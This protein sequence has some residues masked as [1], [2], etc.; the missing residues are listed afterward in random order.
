MARNTLLPGNGNFLRS[1]LSRSIHNVLNRKQD[2]LLGI[3][4]GALL[5]GTAPVLAQ[6][7]SSQELE[8][9]VV[10]GLRG[11]LQASME[12]KRDAIGVVDAINAEDIGKFPGFESQRIPATHHRHLDQPARWRRRTGHGARIRRRIQHGHAERPHDAG[13]GCLSR[14]QRWATSRAFNFANLASESGERGR[15]LQDQQGRHRHRRHRRDGEH[16]D[17]AAARRRRR[18]HRQLRSQGRE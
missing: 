12:T 16:Q 11:S 14:R 6:E 7:P 5:L 15:G 2:A 4:G 8:E 13:G 18:I 10:T 1:E 17:G 9:V 3:L